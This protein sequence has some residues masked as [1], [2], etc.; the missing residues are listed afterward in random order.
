M[1]NAF[2][3]GIETSC[4][5]TSASIVAD[6]K[7]ILSNVT[8]SSLTYH[9][10]YGGIVPE[11]AFR[12]QLETI[13]EVAD[14]ALA[15]AG[16]TIEKTRLISVTDGPG[17]LGS[18]LTGLS[19]AKA[20]SLGRRIP[21]LGVNHLQG[22]IYSSF[23]NKVEPGFPFVALVVSGGHTSLFYVR[24]FDRIALLGATRDD[25]CGE[26]FDKVAKILGLGYPGGPAIERQSKKGDP[27]RIQFGCSNTKEP[28][29]FSFSGIKTGVFYYANTQLRK[30]PGN[31]KLPG[32]IVSDICASFQEAA[33]DSLVAKSLSA[34]AHKRTSQL[35]VAG[36][37]AANN[38]L[39]EKFSQAAKAGGVD[40]YFPSRQFCTDNAAMIAGLGY[41]LFRRGV[42]SPMNLCAVLD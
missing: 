42:R 36:G 27:S 5:E 6:G 10:K 21:L 41:Q 22:H 33:I 17:L 32:P 15:E 39:R 2:V 37:V 31:R 38:R 7:K 26:A 18:L 40:C 1:A 16:L 28:F 11:I 23:F 19:F 29:D 30:Y 35:V 9:K 8:A 13:A 25:A 20:V 34:C 12:M 24:D 14:R 4:D 3:L